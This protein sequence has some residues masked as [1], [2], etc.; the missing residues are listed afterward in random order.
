MK[1]IMPVLLLLAI[2]VAAA[3]WF[4]LRRPSELGA[5]VTVEWRGS[6]RG[7]ARLPAELNW[8]PVTRM[9]TLVAVSNDTGLL[10]TL[11]EQD[12][13][14]ADLHPVIAPVS[15]EVG[16]RPS[17]IATLR[18]AADTGQLLGFRS[19]S[20]MVELSEVGARASGSF[21]IRMQA[22]VGAETLV[23]RGVFRGIP[24]VASAVGCP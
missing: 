15:R 5:T 14:V 7:E 4:V 8:C 13:L 20:G 21:D 18:W 17:A 19:V 12:S 22:P 9:G 23:V 6:R 16:P 11:Q 10:V 24:V 1:R 3:W 2:A